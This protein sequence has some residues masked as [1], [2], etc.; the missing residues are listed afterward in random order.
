MAFYDVVVIVVALGFAIR[1]WIRGAARELIELT[2][3]LVGSLI[4]FRMSPVVGTILAG[5]ANVPY[6]V[7]RVVAGTAVFV[8]LVVGSIVAGRLIAT[9]MHVIPGGAFIN[10]AGGA[11]MGVAFAGLVIVLG[12]T[13]ASATPLPDGA[14]EAIDGAV[15]A[16]PVGRVIVDPTGR[17]QPLVSVAS[18]ERIFGAV[19]AVR[20][21][22]GDRLMAGTLPIPFPDIGGA[23]LLPSQ[24]SAQEVF[25][26]LNRTRI[27]DGADPLAWSPALGAVA[28]ARANEV[29]RSGVLVLDD[30]LDAALAAAGIPGTIHADLVVMAASTDGL[31]EAID[32]AS[33]YRQ[34]ITST[35]FSRAAI[36]VV[37]GPYG[38]IAVQV[39]TG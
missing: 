22:V 38:L 10:K 8:V 33:T 25:D 15:E 1:G 14:K 37:E 34:M 28:V 12:T 32:G 31:V 24:S 16:S 2:L 9:A 26:E 35:A 17:V 20:E 5:M 39:L 18:G 36:G 29:Y 11:A 19:I 23:A 21:A 3:L 27:D 13:L 7:A 30:D 6:E 4:V